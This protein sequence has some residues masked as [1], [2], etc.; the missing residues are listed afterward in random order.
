MLRPDSPHRPEEA[1]PLIVTAVLGAA[2]FLW[3]DNLRKRYYPAE[4]NALPA[5]LSLFRHLPPSLEDELKRELG[6]AARGARPKARVDG[7]MSLANGLAI[8]VRSPDLM[9]IWEELA[10]R[11]AGLLMPLDQSPPRFHITVQNKV[12]PHIA[13]ETRG[14]LEALVISRPLVI[15]GLAC[16]RYLGGPWATVS[17]YGFRG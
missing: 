3:A 14:H 17:S 12:A 8:S 13:R 7:V 1:A 9:E 15:Q 4:R 11:F 16:W 6:K 2:D 10:T 5:H